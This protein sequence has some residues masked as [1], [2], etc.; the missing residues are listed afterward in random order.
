ML[1]SCSYSAVAYG[2]FRHTYAKHNHPGSRRASARRPKRCCLISLLRMKEKV[3]GFKEY[4]LLDSASDV[5]AGRAKSTS[6]QFYVAY[7]IDKMTDA[8]KVLGKDLVSIST[9]WILE[10]SEF[11]SLQ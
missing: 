11:H 4:L 1:N 2:D 6:A 7:E 3:R 8:Y 9:P 5:L 10:L